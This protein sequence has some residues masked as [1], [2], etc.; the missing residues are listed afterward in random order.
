M[1]W[2]F[3]NPK[4]MGWKRVFESKKIECV[5]K[6]SWGF[7]FLNRCQ[8][9]CKKCIYCVGWNAWSVLLHFVAHV[10]VCLV[11]VT[12]LLH[13]TATCPAAQSP[14]WL[15]DDYGATKLGHLPN[16]ID[17]VTTF[18]LGQWCLKMNVVG[19]WTK[20]S[21]ISLFLNEWMH[22]YECENCIANVDELILCG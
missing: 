16:P 2:S 18:G 7:F 1:A 8:V 4:D 21:L 19:G 14:K 22:T 3:H 13:F 6:H 9:K 15:K 12:F 17:Y 11:V 5:D 20:S 10:V